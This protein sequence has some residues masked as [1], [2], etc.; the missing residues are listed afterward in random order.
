MNFGQR[1]YEFY[2][3]RGY[4]PPQAAA[5]AGNAMA[6]SGG[7]PT[8]RGDAG[9]A[10]GIF[11]WHPDRQANLQRFASQAGLDPMS[12]Q[13]QLAFKDWELRNTEAAAGRRLFAATTPEQANAAVLSSLRP[14]G[15]TL[16]D[17]TQ[18]MAY[19]KRLANT[20]SFL[21][22]GAQ[23][24]AVFGQP[25]KTTVEP[26]ATPVYSQDIGTSIR[27]AGNFFFPDAVE[28]PTP[29]TPEQIEAQKKQMAQQAAEF[30]GLNDANATLKGFLSLMQMGQQQAPM[31]QIQDMPIEGGRY[32][33]LPKM[34]GF[35]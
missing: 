4:T 23:S 17:P 1:A 22:D 3:S 26:A 30:K 10:L 27:R 12:E 34:R 21:G 25:D 35:L 29:L 8:I 28:A 15:F 9:K 18:S 20:M 24:Q 2:I 6:E 7:S 13:A 5:L 11:Q 32:R 33:P 19:G 31:T 14:S 16:Q